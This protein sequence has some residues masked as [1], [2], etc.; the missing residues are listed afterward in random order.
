MARLR[1]WVRWLGLLGLVMGLACG[2]AGQAPGQRTAQ[3]R[4]A[5]P[6]ADE[7][8]RERRAL[9]RFV[10]LLERN[11]RRGTALDRVYGYHV[12]RGTLDELIKSYRDRV[13]RDGK[14]GTAALILGLLEFQRG[15]DAAAVAALRQ[16]ESARLNDPLP[17]YYLGQALVLVGQPEQAAEAFERALGRKPARNDLL[18]IFQALGR[19]YQRTQKSDQALAVWSRLEALFPDDTRVQ[20]QIATALAEE[21]QPALALPRFEAL[22]AKVKDPFRQVQMAMQAAELKVRLN[23]T[24][25][26]LKDFETMLGKLRPDSWLHKEV[27]RKIEEV[28]LRNDDRAGLVSY[29]ERWTKRDPEDV[30]A[31]VRLGRTLSTLGRVAEAQPWYEKA[32]KLAPGRRDL[33]LALIGQLAQDQK[34]AEAAAQYEA[35]DR[36]EPNNPDTLKDWGALVLR[37]P[38]RPAP[39]RKAAAAAIWRKLLDARPNDAVTTAQVADLLR[40]AELVDDAI[41]LYRKAS[42]QAPANPQYHEYLGEYLH[43]LKRPAEAM[44]EW[45]K[46]A[47]G[48]SRN[49][50]NLGR[51]A[52]VLAGFGYIKESIAPLQEAVALEKDDFDLRMKLAEYLHRL[53]RFDEAEAQHSAAQAMATRDEQRVAVRESRVKNDQAA[54]RMATRIAT[55]RQELEARP[56]SPADRWIELARYLEADSK[57]PD[58]VR[59]TDRA[60]QADGR[61]VPAWTLAGRVRESAG[62]L[63]DAAAAL[64]RLTEIDRKN[65]AEY[66]EGIARLESRLGRVD[67]AIKAGRELLAATAAGPEHCEFFA[68]LCFQHGRVEEG[69]DALRRAVRANPRDTRAVLTLAET[70]AGQYQTEEAIEM[71]WR[72]FDRTEDLDHKL[73]VVRRLTELYL[74]RNQLDRLLT[75]LQHQE[76]DDRPAGGAAPAAQGRDV[77][78]CLAQAYASSG[79]LGAARAE[80][81]RLLA[82]NTRDTQ[83]LTQLSKLA[84]EEGDVDGAARYQRQ[85]VELAPSD[86]GFSRLGQLFARSGDLEEAQSVWSK[87]AGGQGSALHVYLAMDSLIFHQK[88]A[89]V[90]E[91]SEVLLR[92]DPHDWEALYRRGAAAAQLDRADEAERAFRAL[93]DVKLS[94]DEPSAFSKARARNPRLEAPNAY[95]ILGRLL[96]NSPMEERLGLVPAIRWFCRLASSPLAQRYSWSPADFGQA[97]IAAMGWLVNLAQKQGSQH[98]DELVASIRR[99]AENKPA[100]LR[101]LWDW[102]YLCAVRLDNPGVY[103]AAREVSRAAPADPIALWAYLHS[104]GGRQTPLGQRATAIIQIRNQEAATASLPLDKDELDYVLSCFRS[105]QARRP[106]LAQ[107]EILQYVDDEL[108]RAKRSDAEK[109]F[110][111]DVV[112][113]ASRIGQVAAALNIAARRGDVDAL[114]ELAER[115]ERL[116]AGRTTPGFT[117]GSFTFAAGAGLSISQGMS[118][119]ADRKAYADVLRL[120]DL[121]L[122]ATRRKME[123]QSTGAAAR[124]SRTRSALF[125]AL[126]ARTTQRIWIGSSYRTVSIDFP[127]SNEY[128]DSDAIGVLR[129]A[130]EL[131]KRDD[132]LSDLVAHF[133]GQA[134]AATSSA[135][136]IYP[137]L[138]LSAILWWSDSKDEAIAEL[139]RVADASRPESDIRLDLVELMEQ[140]GD[141][142][143]ALVLVDAVQPLDNFSL[144]RREELALRL[145]ARTGNIERAR[146]AAER[147]FGLRLDTDTQ[148]AVAG[149]MHQLGLHELAEALL[150]RARRRAGNKTSALVGLML[151]YQRQDKLDQAVQVAMQILR[152]T[153]AAP[154]TGPLTVRTIAEDPTT[155][156]TAATSVLARSGRLAQLIDRANEEL[157]KAPNAVPLHQALADYY[158]AARQPAKARAEW[159]KVVELRPDD[160]NLR[161]RIADQLAQE[162]QAEAAVAHYV[163]V[164]K[165][166]PSQFGRIDLAQIANTCRKAGKLDDLLQFLQDDTIADANPYVVVSLIQEVM[167]ENRLHDRAMAAFRKFWKATPS[168]HSSLL[169]YLTR[170]EIWQLPEIY[171]AVR[172]AILAGNTPTSSVYAQ[173]FPFRVIG[174]AA[175][176]GPITNTQPASV[177][178]FLDVAAARDRLDD[179]AR[180]IAATRK[181]R[182]DWTPGDFFLAMVLCRAG[183]FDEARALVR[184]L[185]DPGVK[186]ESLTSSIYPMYAYNALMTEL[187]A[188]AETA[189]LIPDVCRR[190]GGLP[191]SLSFLRYGLEQHPVGRLITRYQR[192]GQLDDARRVALELVRAEVP[193]STDVEVARQYKLNALG[194]IARKLDELGHSADAVPLY[195][196]ALAQAAPLNPDSGVLLVDARTYPQQLRSELE[197]ALGHLDSEALAPIVGRIIADVTADPASPTAK[198]ESRSKTGPSRDQALDLVVLVHPRALDRATVR[199]LLAESL[200]ACDA[201]QLAALDEP[202]EKL[203]RAH[204]DDLSVA[205]ASALRALASGESSR[206]VPALERLDRLVERTPLEPLPPGARANARQ[207]DEAAI[208]V[209]LWL[210]A[211][212]CDSASDAANHRAVAERLAARALEAARRQT[213][214]TAFMAML[215]EQG[216]RALARGDHKSAEAAWTKML[217]TVIAPTTVTPR[218]PTPG[219]R[220]PA[221]SPPATSPRAQQSRERQRAVPAPAVPRS[222]MAAARLPA[223]PVRRVSFQDTPKGQP[224]TPRARATP[225]ARARPGPAAGLPILTLDRFEQ[226]MQIARLATERDLP[227]LSFRAVRESLQAGPPIVPANPTADALALRRARAGIEQT[228]VDTI[229]PRVAANLVAIDRLWEEHHLSPDRVY[230]VLRGVVL[231]PG[232]PSEIFL[233]APPPNLGALRRTRSAGAML[234]AW[235]VRAGKVDDL[236]K[237]VDERKGSPLAGLPAAVLTVQLATAS[238]DDAAMVAG[239]KALAARLQRDTLQ[240]S[241]QLACHAALPALQR[242]RPDVTAAAM[243]VLDRCVAGFE[244]TS[245][246]EPLGTLLLLL[247]RRQSQLGDASGARKRLDAYIEA[248]ERNAGRLAGDSSLYARKQALARVATEYARAGVVSDAMTTLGRYADIPG[249]PSSDPVAATALSR[250]LGWLAARPA[251]EGYAALHDWT[252]PASDRRSVRILAMSDA[253]AST[254]LEGGVVPIPA[255]DS[256]LCTATTLIGFARQAGALD[257]LADE[258]RA[259]AA[260]KVDNAEVFQILV[261]IARSQAAQVSHRIEARVSERLRQNQEQRVARSGPG[262]RTPAKPYVHD[263]L[264]ARVALDS[265][266]PSMAPL[267]RPLA[268]ALIAC[269]EGDGEGPLVARL[270]RAVA[271]ADARRAGAPHAVTASLPASWRSAAIR[272]ENSTPDGPAAIWIAHQ[273]HV[274]H[275]AGSAGDLLVFDYPLSG[276]YELSLDAYAGPSAASGIV[277]NGV[278]ILPSAPGGRAQV[279]TLAR[280][281]ITDVPWRLS[282]PVGFNRLT[283]QA[284]PA[285]VRYLVN[286]HLLYQDDD[287]SLASPW[288]GLFA[289]HDRSAWRNLT[290][291]GHPTIPREVRLSHGDRLDGWDCA[292]YGETQPPHP[293]SRFGN[294]GPTR[295]RR[296]GRSQA[297]SLKRRPTINT[298]DF[299][300]AAGDGVIHGRRTNFGQTP[301]T[302]AEASSMNAAMEADQSRLVYHRPLVDGDAIAYEFLYEPG[303]IMVH[304]ALGRLAFLLEPEGV[305]LHWMTTGAN[306][307]S[308]LPADNAVGQPANPGGPRAVPLKL[309][310][311]NAMRLSLSGDRLTID[312][313]SQT[314]YEREHPMLSSHERQFGLFHFKDQTSARVRNVVLKG[315][316]PEV[317]P[318]RLQADLVALPP[319]ERPN[320]AMRR[321]R[322]AIVGEE[323]FAL[324]AGAIVEKARALPPN[325]RYVMLADWVLPNPDHPLVRLEGDFTPSYPVVLSPGVEPGGR[326]RAPAIELVAVARELGEL[327][328]LL[329]RVE[330]LKPEADDPFAASERGRLALLSMI[331]AARADDAAATRAIEALDAMRKPLP[332]DLDEYAR[333]PEL[334]AAHQA[335][336]R[337]A[338]RKPALALAVALNARAE[339]DRP[340][341]AQPRMPSTVWETQVNALRSRLEQTTHE[342]RSAPDDGNIPEL[343]TPLWKQVTQTTARSRGEGQPMPRWTFRDGTLSHRPGH[344]D[345]MM[346]LAVPLRGTF[347]FDCE[348]TAPAGREIRVVYAGQVLG[349]KADGKHL[350]RGQ[351]GRPSSEISIN[352]P[353]DQPG[354]WYAWRLAVDGNRMS[355]SINGRKVHEAVLP[356][357]C[358]PWLALLCPANQSGD[359]RKVIISGRPQIPD[360]LNLS[361]SAD[362]AGWRSD[363]YADTTTGERADW[364]KRGEEIVGRLD[365]P[366]P[367]ARRESV[368]RYHRPMLEDG[369]ITYEFYYDPGKAMVH[370]ALDR[371]AFLLEPDGVRIHLLTDGADERSGLAPDNVRDDTES[372]RGP[373]SLPLNPQAWNR[374]VVEIRGDKVT[375][376]LNGQTI[377]ERALA[378]ANHRGFGLFHYA[379]A[380]QA[381]VRNVTYQGQWPRSLP[382]EIGQ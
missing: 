330:A 62:N 278:S 154:A 22:A 222:L 7:E 284:S 9:E 23:R 5:D 295:G 32:I 247:A 230:E 85:L 49:A 359:A 328:E 225:K 234:A 57:L 252:M 21:D 145:S 211:R 331:H 322:H 112:S 117:T 35:L 214:N 354:E 28:F 327:D 34:Y 140:Q 187:E 61:S 97:R 151:Q 141:Y 318:D 126:G 128:L 180:D 380:T 71:Y 182:P 177:A 181:V 147:L 372:R 67:E 358:D 152:S 113:G 245:Q 310:E 261:E 98:V 348:L 122:A 94:D 27:R 153:P 173:W 248:M 308:G 159:I 218:R 374:L 68:Q 363:E 344:A 179:L 81:D 356:A 158:T 203:R 312:L 251:Q 281:G 192:Q 381:R 367:G 110:Y 19:V 304:P 30:E 341:E 109:G 324:E 321:A 290:L 78:M 300:W 315:N 292:F 6:A 317:F 40:Q 260:Q 190:A 55:M 38:S 369:R 323:L 282:R 83:L 253:A 289:I 64:R 3:D 329:S 208:Q 52:E 8:V 267:A 349:L 364:E 99:P 332:I 301:G 294:P 105:L 166:D 270:R 14:D 229:T 104:L 58:A 221:A 16:A 210:V 266:D 176:T 326:L 53:G 156:R 142:A 148:I 4:P 124:A 162:G 269:A 44:A 132:L 95:P 223:V 263:E 185:A 15:Q 79:D 131:Y 339:K 288:L 37:D 249:S 337:P 150:G 293:A 171:D 275:A 155:A 46:I 88:P 371:V 201:Q 114:V 340:T 160:H 123:R 56:D 13:T 255:G 268:Q 191:Y 65:R 378:P 365:T 351:I 277:H 91:T 26:A 246:S 279:F 335:S 33:R 29:Y 370:P 285:Q 25:E 320:D 184:R 174:L 72:A 198:D 121:N 226:A 338:L 345:D 355:V 217:E 231:P 303:R 227:D 169:T 361:A 197:S 342:E 215:R 163:F 357:E 309:G 134:D 280:E 235:A 379:D 89:P 209:P 60:I 352:P 144:R 237:A 224:A 196:K 103:T 43:Q 125:A 306:D 164:M 314:V 291:T 305:K 239:L 213:D 146:Q 202:L 115:Y 20:E 108:N 100:D 178:R 48:S 274:A 382:S 283:I 368:L 375:L 183:R 87:L 42:E 186:D 362:L 336:L 149:Q 157:K 325:Q 127:Q 316:W 118:V 259:A 167:E 200:A 347:A 307:R 107:A 219:N 333:W 69:L 138:A 262:S 54:G 334:V 220:A 92:K 205:I 80:L 376:E 50:R 240:S 120:L 258:A 311:W 377:Y 297:G 236:K 75:R 130:F 70:L 18:E 51:L 90:L 189:D 165:K 31:L 243:A 264:I 1:K 373:A 116:Q 11:P 172:D 84:E 45:A 313:N 41:A 82:A 206:I 233:Y 360:K 207:R 272:P 111:H 119:C 101:A 102:L 319:S 168:Y 296:E 136:A 254:M 86:D 273:G 199:S 77:G 76:R 106:E 257:K 244:N 256:M 276:T 302:I 129:T 193:S 346:Y 73:D 250:V 170:E 299:D 194:V 216:D 298:E 63:G 36:A 242:S 366:I 74:Q 47:E 24:E 2:L 195:S 139:G 137:R 143:A 353:I 265:D 343:N 287:P 133:R 12:E 271:K 241:A 232:R 66:L 228:T 10:A 39:E 17:S 96:T 188:H 59:A 93:L 350:E 204:P 135:A 175:V 286:G 212:A 161:L 238:G